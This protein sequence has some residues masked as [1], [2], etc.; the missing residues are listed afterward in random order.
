MEKI[1]IKLYGELA[2]RFGKE[3]K[4]AVK[5]PAEAVR[6][7]CANFKDFR[8]FVSSSEDRNT[9]YEVVVDSTNIC[10]EDDEEFKTSMHSTM[11]KEIKIIPHIIGGAAAVRIVVGVVLIVVGIIYEQPWMVSMGMSLVMGG[12]A[13]LLSPV[14]KTTSPTSAVDEGYAFSSAIN[15]V[16]QGNPVAIGYGEMI[17]GSQLISAGIKTVDIAIEYV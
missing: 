12:V 6:A 14:N 15:N 10:S 2:K 5:T 16:G 3:H 9:G 7:L 1:T 8:S 4:L 13:E 11:Q 17:V